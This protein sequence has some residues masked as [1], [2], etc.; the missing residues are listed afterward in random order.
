MNTKY[1][2]LLVCAIGSLSMTPKIN[3]SIIIDTVY[4]GDLNNPNGPYGFSFDTNARY[5]SVSYGYGI[6]KYHK[7]PVISATTAVG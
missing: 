7:C 5:G 6:G 1:L 2:A 4:V 3:A